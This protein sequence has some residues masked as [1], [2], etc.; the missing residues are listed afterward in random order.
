MTTLAFMSVAPVAASPL[1]A[2]ATPSLGGE[3]LQVVLSLAGVVL[4]IVAAGWLSRRVQARTRPGGRRLRCVESIAL[5][6]RERVLLLDADGKRLLLGVGAG[7]V[8]TLH[9][10]D[11][12]AQPVA[13]APTPSAP[14]SPF[15][16]LLAGWRT[17]R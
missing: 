11:G 17:R 15:A 12:E 4:L 14:A 6:A 10:Y 16:E 8:R 1:A 13:E 2:G 9:V 3:L 5:G 7:G